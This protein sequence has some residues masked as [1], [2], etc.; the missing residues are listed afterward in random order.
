MRVVVDR[1]EVILPFLV[2]VAVVAVVVELLHIL[3]LAIM[4][5]LVLQTQEAVAVAVDALVNW[6]PLA[7][8]ELLLSSG[9]S[10]NGLLC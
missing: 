6:E 4:R 7:V 9:D 2:G 10:N 8:K 1:Q 3:A 5:L